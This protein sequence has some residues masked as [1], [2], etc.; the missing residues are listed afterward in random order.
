MRTMQRNLSLRGSGRQRGFT[1]VELMVVVALMG[2]V[3]GFAVPSMKTALLNNKLSSYANS[4]AGSVGLA[5]SE[6]IKR[7]ATITICRSSSGTAC[8]TTGNLQQGWIVFN[9]K[10][11]DGTVDSDETLLQ[12]Q[13]SL[14]T[15][16]SFVNT[17]D[18]TVYTF[19]FQPTGVGATSAV[20]VL[21]RTDGTGDS[22]RRIAVS[23]TARIYSE[24]E[25]GGTCP[26]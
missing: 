2:I 6:A 4:F 14:A 20:L 7:N 13:E 8:A 9:D 19:T 24:K 26:A 15:D 5:K 1:M 22:R 17:T 11:S 10:D 3:L 21:C 18:N 16:F 12:R 23:A 25:S